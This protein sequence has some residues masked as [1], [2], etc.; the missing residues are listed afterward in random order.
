MRRFDTAAKRSGALAGHTSN[1][2]RELLFTSWAAHSTSHIPRLAKAGAGRDDATKA[3]ELAGSGQS[4][5]DGISE[6]QLF[7]L[8]S[9]FTRC[10]AIG[11]SLEVNRAICNIALSSAPVFRRAFKCDANHSPQINFTW[12]EPPDDDV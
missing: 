6:D 10:G 7:F 3:G 5:F 2:M 1:E 12:P 8:V 4:Y 9:C 11:R